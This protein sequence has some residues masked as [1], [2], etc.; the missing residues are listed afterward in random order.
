MDGNNFNAN[1][2]T[3]VCEILESMKN[4]FRQLEYAG[5]GGTEK[6]P[7]YEIY[8][9]VS[10]EDSD[11]SSSWVNSTDVACSISDKAEGLL[12]KITDSFTNYIKNTLRNEDETTSIIRNINS[13]LEEDIELLS[14]IEV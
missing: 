6:Y 14:K 5:C 1:E 7:E 2:L 11:L 4:A 3:E 12:I 10:S 8:N 9:L 13:S